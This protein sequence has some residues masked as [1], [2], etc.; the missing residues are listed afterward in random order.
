MAISRK[1]EQ[2]VVDRRLRAKQ[3][4]VLICAIAEAGV[5]FWN[6]RIGEVSSFSVDDLG[7]VYFYDSGSR[8][9]LY[10]FNRA[11][12][13]SRS[14]FSQGGTFKQMVDYL[15]AFVKDGEQAPACLFGPWPEYMCGGD[16][17]GAGKDTAS[18]LREIAVCLGVAI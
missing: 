7:R 5:A 10:M 3:V 12:K 14:G 17:F 16:I 8:S 2:V 6:K 1:Q 13:R 9:K 18:R 15:L 4:N 11:W